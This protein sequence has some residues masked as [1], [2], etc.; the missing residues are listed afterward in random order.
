MRLAE[1]KAFTK[2]R[3]RIRFIMTSLDIRV[4]F[5]FIH[6]VQIFFDVMHGRI[7]GKPKSWKMCRVVLSPSRGKVI[8]IVSENRIQR[9]PLCRCT[10]VRDT[11][12]R[13]CICYGVGVWVYMFS[14]LVKASLSS[15]F[16]RKRICSHSS[17]RRVIRGRFQLHRFLSLIWIQIDGFVKYCF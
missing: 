9:T 8:T 3:D 14:F 4:C 6:P 12:T 10:C 15:R 7:G 5:F 16:Q 11:E 13:V 2:T 1:I 17:H